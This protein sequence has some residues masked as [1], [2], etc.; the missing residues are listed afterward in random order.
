MIID[1]NLSLALSVCLQCQV[2][3]KTCNVEFKGS[4]ALMM[5]ARS[6]G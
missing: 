3:E 5:I 4:D 6:D 2:A 1:F